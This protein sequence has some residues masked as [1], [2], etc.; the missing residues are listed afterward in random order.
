MVLIFALI[1]TTFGISFI[2]WID[3]KKSHLKRVLCAWELQISNFYVFQG[4]AATY[5]RCGGNLILVLLEIYCS[6]QQWKNFGNPSRI[7]KVI[8]MV[9]VAPFFD[10]QCTTSG[11]LWADFLWSPYVIGQTIIFS[12]C[13]FFLL[14]SF[15]PRLISAVGNWMFTILCHMVW[16]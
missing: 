16:P 8:A 14:F 5:L 7:D 4:N 11:K 2:C 9:R 12:S 15:F 3:D 13:S 1:S 10:A 6:L